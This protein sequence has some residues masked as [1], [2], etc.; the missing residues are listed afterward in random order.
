MS[1][2][3][4]AHRFAHRLRQQCCIGG[5]I[6]CAVMPIATRALDPDQIHRTVFHAQHIGNAVA[7][8]PGS[9]GRRPQRGAIGSHIG[10]GARRPDRCVLLERRVVLGTDPLGGTGQGTVDIAGVRHRTDLGRRGAHDGRHVLVVRQHRRKAPLH[11]QR[12]CGTY[13]LLFTLGH[14]ANKIASHHHPHIARQIL[15]RGFI[16]Q[17]R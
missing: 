5:A 8:E 3:L 4:Q 17:Y 15:H 2:P 12:A 11:L 6:V 9:L 16:H 13:G 10:N 7:G 14:H 1:H